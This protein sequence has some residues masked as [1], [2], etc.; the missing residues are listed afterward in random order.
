M[1]NICFWARLRSY[2]APKLEGE[3]RKDKTT[4]VD[5]GVQSCCFYGMSD[6][7]I[8]HITGGNVGIIQDS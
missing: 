3:K 8:A 2:P 1:V 6:V 5:Y 4:W 7:T